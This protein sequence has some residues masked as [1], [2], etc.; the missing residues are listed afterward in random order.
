MAIYFIGG[1]FICS[2]GGLTL[3]ASRDRLKVR[4][5]GVAKNERLVGYREDLSIA[6]DDG[7]L[8]IIADRNTCSADALWLIVAL[9]KN[10]DEEGPRTRDACLLTVAKD[11]ES[12]SLLQDYY[13][14]YD[15]IAVR[16]SVGDK[17]CLLNC[18]CALRFIKV[19]RD[20]SVDDKTLKNPTIGDLQKEFSGMFDFQPEFV[21]R[22]SSGSVGLHI[23]DVIVTIFNAAR[24]LEKGDVIAKDG[25][26]VL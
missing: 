23:S 8:S 17:F 7:E 1:D 5:R 21:R 24:G 26:V 9:A 6:D 20:G 22:Y 3:A 25:L 13:A 16:A 19:R 10:D 2:N 12:R 18:Y 14:P 11:V 15:V 4:T